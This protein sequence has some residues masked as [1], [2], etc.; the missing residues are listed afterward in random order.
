MAT[1]WTYRR[2]EAYCSGPPEDIARRVATEIVQTRAAHLHMDFPEMAATPVLVPLPLFKLQDEHLPYDL[3]RR[4]ESAMLCSFCGLA[5]GDS[6]L[7]GLGSTTPH[8]RSDCPHRDVVYAQINGG[9]RPRTE[10]LCD[11]GR[12]N[13]EQEDHLTSGCWVLIEICR[14]CGHRGHTISRC[15]DYTVEA[16]DEFHREQIRKLH[17]SF[18][19]APAW[20]ADRR[21]RPALHEL[22]AIRGQSDV[23]WAESELADIAD[24]L[25]D[26]QEVDSLIEERRMRS[27]LE[28]VIKFGGSR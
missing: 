2:G 22:V 20:R 16:S 12:C 9:K 15:G 7:P 3:R 18:S 24:E 10:S 1:N 6:T 26:A 13:P 25:L 5:G 11:T 17:H 8:T 27:Y 23:I 19:R 4:P 28:T 21:C 14:L